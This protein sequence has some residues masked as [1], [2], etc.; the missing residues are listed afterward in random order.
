MN[1]ELL[2]TQVFAFVKAFRKIMMKMANSCQNQ[3]FFESFFVS[4]EAIRRREIPF[5]APW[6]IPAP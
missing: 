6:I 3:V 4:G 2:S 5:E 1:A